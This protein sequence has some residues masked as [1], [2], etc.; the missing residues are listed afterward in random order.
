M[1]RIGFKKSLTLDDLWILSAKYKSVQV[2]SQFDR[3]WNRNQQNHINTIVKS[4]DHFNNNSNNN[5]NNKDFKRPK[6]LNFKT[7][8]RFSH[9]YKDILFTNNNQCFISIG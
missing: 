6:S 2:T 5:H 9:Y 8:R 7:D 3:N 4:D 1:T